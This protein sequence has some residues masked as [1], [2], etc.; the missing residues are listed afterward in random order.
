MDEYPKSAQT[1]EASSEDF[2]LVFHAAE[3]E[4]RRYVLR[5]RSSLPTYG[6]VGEEVEAVISQ[7]RHLLLIV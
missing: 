1:R 7:Q 3:H 4:V 2:A 5:W 6:I